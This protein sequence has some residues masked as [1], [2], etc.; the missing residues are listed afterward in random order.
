MRKA[1]SN[2]SAILG[3]VLIQPLRRWG[4]F[5]SGSTRVG[6]SRQSGVDKGSGNTSECMADGVVG[7]FA[8]G[9][10]ASQKPTKCQILLDNDCDWEKLSGLFAGAKQADTMTHTFPDP[11]GFTTTTTTSFL[12]T[13]RAVSASDSQSS[14]FNSQVIFC[15]DLGVSSLFKLEWTRDSNITMV[16]HTRRAAWSM[17]W[18]DWRSGFMTVSASTGSGHDSGSKQVTGHSHKPCDCDLPR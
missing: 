17:L 3:S 9:F 15:F 4:T 8:C 1:F 14:S 18:S 13:Q 11:S 5:I 2:L 10:W 12:L 6:K 7:P 16:C